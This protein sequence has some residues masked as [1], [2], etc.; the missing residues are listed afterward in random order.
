[1]AEASAV[2]E[3]WRFASQALVVAVGWWVVNGLTRAR[4][5]EKAKA[6]SLVQECDALIELADEIFSLV[7]SY[8]TTVRLIEAEIK[9]VM[10]FT[11]LEYRVAN[12]TLLASSR[13]LLTPIRREVI[14]LKQ[15]STGRHFEDEH[16]GPL[17][18]SD[19]V[20]SAV[21]DAVLKIKRRLTKT[22]LERFQ[23]V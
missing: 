13:F 11:D 6:D 17:G 9:I 14:A 16:L 5:N 10:K 19:E 23:L 15:A 20:L 1:M 18:Q 3:F 2:V 12:L 8:H 7:Y 22:K 4:E 21:A